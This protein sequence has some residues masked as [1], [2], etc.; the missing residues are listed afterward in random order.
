MPCAAAAGEVLGTSNP[1]LMSVSM[2]P[3][4]TPWT[5]TPRPFRYA[6]SDCVML[7]AAAFEIE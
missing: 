2:G 7:A 4:K 3:R 1:L 6:R 5:V